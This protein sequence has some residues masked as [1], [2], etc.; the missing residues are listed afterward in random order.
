M[1]TS[2]LSDVVKILIFA[3]AII[4]TCILVALGFRAADTAKEISN[5]AVLQMAELNN[6]LKDSNI[7]MYDGADLY[8]SEVVNF[9]KKN[10]GD[11]T[12][13]ES[14]PIYVYVKTSISENAYTNGS[15]ITNIRNFS[16]TMYIKPTAKF[17]GAAV[18][19]END[20]ILGITFIQQ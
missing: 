20:I 10:L 6:D 1:R 7:K 2:F 12:A 8:G 13:S 18:E 5:S 15:N 16:N 17:L 3:A 4:I 14:A 19:N 11:F 9:I